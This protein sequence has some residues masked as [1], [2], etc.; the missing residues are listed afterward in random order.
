MVYVWTMPM[1][2]DA[3]AS[4]AVMLMVWFWLSLT[5]FWLEL[6]CAGEVCPRERVLPL[7]HL[8]PATARQRAVCCADA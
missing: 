2:G 4:V 7:A 3:D 5:G 8:T 1:D 6:P